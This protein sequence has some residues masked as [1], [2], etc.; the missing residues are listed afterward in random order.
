MAVVESGVD[1]GDDDR[2]VADAETRPHR[3][4]LDLPQP[5]QCVVQPIRV[6]RW[7]VGDLVQKIVGLGELDFGHGLEDGHGVL[8]AQ[9]LGQANVVQ[10]QRIE[11]PDKSCRV[12]GQRIVTIDLADGRL[13]LNEDLFVDVRS[14]SRPGLLP[15][16]SSQ[17]H[18][19]GDHGGRGDSTNHAN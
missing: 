12:P 3:L 13:E 14:W 9:S 8:D 1:V 2:P 10:I 11:P 16:G 7:R 17:P 15:L 6:V 4:H 5:P 19:Q 18:R